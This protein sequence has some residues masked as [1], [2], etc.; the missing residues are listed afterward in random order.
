MTERITGGRMRVLALVVLIVTFVAGA[1]MGVAFER[2]LAAD[3]PVRVERDARADRD[4]GKNRDDDRSPFAPD[5]PLDQRLDLSAEQHARIDS[6]LA[7]QRER[8]DS[9]MHSMRPVLRATYDSTNAAIRSVLTPEQQTEFEAYRQERREH[10][11]R[12]YDRDGR[13]R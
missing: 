6:L 10:I 9:I 7:R 13:R 11:K 8:Y 4:G 3:P 2:V 5:G 12:R 1:L